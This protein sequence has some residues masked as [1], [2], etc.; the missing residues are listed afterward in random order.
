MTD[1]LAAVAEAAAALNAAK[2][3]R[4]RAIMS[5]LAA[6]VSPTAIARA[7]RLHRSRVYQIK[8]SAMTVL[9]SCDP[10]DVLAQ[11]G[12]GPEYR[13]ADG[14]YIDWGS[15]DDD[16]QDALRVE[17]AALAETYGR[18]WSAMV[19]RVA[20]ERGVHADVYVGR[21]GSRLD[22]MGRQGAAETAREIWQEA[23]D[24]LSVHVVDGRWAVTS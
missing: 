2:D 5:A 17:Q 13:T 1:H 7:A 20:A 6:D 15:L 3:A 22:D 4:D 8:E 14:S 9:V 21:D 12:Q 11:A 19:E 16:T 24:R 18:E 10:A 23:H